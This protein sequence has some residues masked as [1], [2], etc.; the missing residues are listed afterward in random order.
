MTADGTEQERVRH[1]AVIGDPVAHSKSPRMHGAAYRALGMPHTYEALRVDVDGLPTVMRALR[2]GKYDGL[3]VTVPHKQRV[4][5][6]VDLVDPSA[7]AVGAANTLVRSSDGT[8]VAH[9]TDVPA[10]VAELRA[11][12]PERAD[13]AAWATKEAL[14]IGSGG[15]ARAAVMALAIAGARLITVRARALDKAARLAEE[16]MRSGAPVL[17]RE[18]PLRA[19]PKDG[20][21]GTIVQATSAGMEG[22]DAGE[23]VSGAVH[24]DLLTSDTVA[25]DV[26][27]A[28][29]ETHFLRAGFSR[30]LR[31]ANG[32]GM[33][34]GQ[35]ALAFELWLGVRAPR[36]VM[37]AALVS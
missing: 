28:P 23:S 22:A 29:P 24:W 34:T 6:Y 7:R 5:E 3:N 2:E 1:F 36:D 14:V 19:T 8:L 15:A 11:L 27:Y 33:L 37:R 21:F 12:A 9:N 10:L 16:V 32:F 17:I 4:M 18:Q 31:V 30:G 26:V 13:D 20:S 35:G 25:L